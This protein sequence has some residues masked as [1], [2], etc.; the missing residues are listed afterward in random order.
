MSEAFADYIS[1]YLKEHAIQFNQYLL[2]ALNSEDYSILYLE[3]SE[4]LNTKSDDLR[5][6]EFLASA[7]T[8]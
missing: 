3:S 2:K 1:K 6:C 8:F 5:N 4:G 7:G